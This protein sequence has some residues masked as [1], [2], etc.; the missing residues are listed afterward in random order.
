MKNIFSIKD[1]VILVTGA[2]GY[3]GRKMVEHL[4][5][6]DAKVIALSRDINKLE[7]LANSLSISHEQIFEMDI[8]NKQNVQDIFQK[9]FQKCLSV[10]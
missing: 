1:K 5:K 8:S 9:I 4:V 2:T 3:L 6:A 7:K 10:I